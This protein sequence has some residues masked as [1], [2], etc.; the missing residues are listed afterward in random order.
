[1]RS[2]IAQAGLARTV[3]VIEGNALEQLVHLQTPFDL[4]LI[5][6]WKD[7]YPAY[8]D[9]VFSRLR[10]GGVTVANS[11]PAKAGVCRRSKSTFRRRGRIQMRRAS[12]CRWAA[13]LR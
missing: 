7:D 1:M 2:A 5:D 12:R 8:F 10:V 9:L 3:R 6:A 4:V 11:V 13:G